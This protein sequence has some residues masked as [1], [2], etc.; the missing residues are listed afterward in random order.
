MRKPARAPLVSLEEEGSPPREEG[1][2]V[3]GGDL[4]GGSLGG[5]RLI[6]SELIIPPVTLSLGA[7]RLKNTM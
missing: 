1:F 2:K 3:V 4:K 5:R 7:R 6:H